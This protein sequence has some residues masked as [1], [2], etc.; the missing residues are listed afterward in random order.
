MCD[1]TR[2]DSFLFI[3]SSDDLTFLVTI[4]EIR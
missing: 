2:P 3:E 1:N 4:L